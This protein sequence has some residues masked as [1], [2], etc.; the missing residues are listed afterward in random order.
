MEDLNQRDVDRT[1]EH[2]RNHHPDLYRQT[3]TADR[4][5][6][7]VCKAGL[8]A[9]ATF[10]EFRQVVKQWYL[11]Y[12]RGTEVYRKEHGKS[13]IGVAERVLTAKIALKNS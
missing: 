11:L 5:I 4:H 13:E 7:V 8:T 2:I 6:D 1:S 10:E 9:K 3:T 12:L